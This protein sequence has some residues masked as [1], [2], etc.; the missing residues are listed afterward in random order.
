MALWQEHYEELKKSLEKSIR[1]ETGV[2]ELSE[3][4]CE[5]NPRYIN[6]IILD[7]LMAEAKDSPMVYR[8]GICL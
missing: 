1:S 6:I 2:P 5:I 3:D 7:D 8:Y 4:L